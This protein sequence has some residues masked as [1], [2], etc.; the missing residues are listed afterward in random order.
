MDERKQ[1]TVIKTTDGHDNIR[2]AIIVQ[3]AEELKRALKEHNKGGI[4]TLEK[5]FKSEWGEAL[6][7]G[8]SVYIIQRIKKEVKRG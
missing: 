7:G 4:K 3:A 1:Y 5:W 6:S 8:N 2:I